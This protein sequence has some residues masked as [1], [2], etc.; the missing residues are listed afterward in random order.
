MIERTTGRS[1]S[2]AALVALALLF[3]LGRTFAADATAT[4]GDTIKLD[5]TSYKLDGIDAP[6]PDQ[7]CLGPSGTIWMCGLEARNRLAEIIGKGTVRCND[8]GPDPAYPRRHI[9]E[10]WIDGEPASLNQRLVREGWAMN[11]EPYA[12]GRFNRDEGDARANLRGLWAGCFI[13]PRDLRYWNKAKAKLW[14]AACSSVRDLDV[15]NALFPDHPSM[16][17]GCSIKGTMPSRAQLT[18]HRGIYHL[19]GCRSYRTT[20]NPRRWFCSEEEAQ[21]G[22]FRKALTCPGKPSR[23]STQL[24]TVFWLA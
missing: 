24:T 11:F 7:A 19:E 9:G 21:A 4:D 12:R 16:P 18:G 20:T 22:G 10:C 17:P 5:G 13:A 15:R 8:K 14:G 6:E 3:F 1:I 23:S 2:C